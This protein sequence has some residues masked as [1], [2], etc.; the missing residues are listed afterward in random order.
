MWRKGNTS[1]ITVSEIQLTVVVLLISSRSGCPANVKLLVLV[2]L[3][4]VKSSYTTAEAQN[5]LALLCTK[6]K[7]QSDFSATAE[8][9]CQMLRKAV[10]YISSIKYSYSL[11]C[12]NCCQVQAKGLKTG[13]ATFTCRHV[14]WTGT[15]PSM[16]IKPCTSI[17]HL[18]DTRQTTTLSYISYS[19]RKG[20]SVFL[21]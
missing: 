2:L 3:Q 18:T 17:H 21:F 4:A 14:C 19:A 9:Q 13:Q 16:R 11:D 10:P 20:I 6:H 1:G 7:A 12:I 8:K 15:T 5:Y